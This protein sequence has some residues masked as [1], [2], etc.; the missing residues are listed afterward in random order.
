VKEHSLCFLDIKSILS[1]MQ[2]LCI[3]FEFVMLA[4]LVSVCS[5]SGLN[6]PDVSLEQRF[7]D[8]NQSVEQLKLNYLLLLDK[9]K[10]LT[11]NNDHIVQ[12]KTISS[13]NLRHVYPRC[14]VTNE[15]YQSWGI[16]P[17]GGFYSGG[18]QL[19]GG[20]G[21]FAGVELQ[22]TWRRTF[23]GWLCCP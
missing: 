15:Y 19:P 13:N 14:Y 11:E 22:N 20:N 18:W 16:C 3:T 6:T 8:F 5:G 7:T 10:Q 21:Q 17:Y 4:L 12:N 1:A 9:Y 2:R 23:N